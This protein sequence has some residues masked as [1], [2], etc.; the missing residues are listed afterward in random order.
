MPKQALLIVAV[1]AAGGLAALG[2]HAYARQRNA[3]WTAASPEARR[4]FEQGL[5]AELKFYREDAQAHYKKALEL[6][7]QMAMAALRLVDFTAPREKDELARRIADLKTLREQLA[8]RLSE[9]ERLLI[10]YRL[11][12]AAK[13]NARAEKTLSAYLEQHPNDPWA[14]SIRCDQ[15]WQRRDYKEAEKCNRLLIK[16][17]PNWVQAQNQLGYIAMATGRFAEAEQLFRTYLYIAPDQANPHDSMGELFTLLGRYPE[18]ERELEAAVRIRPSFCT[19]WEHL[20]LLHD[21]AGASDKAHAAVDRVEALG[22]CSKDFVERQRC[23]VGT[24]DGVLKNDPAESWQAASSMGCSGKGGEVSVLAYHAALR[25]GHD[26]DAAIIESDMREH[27][28]LYG[29]DDPALLALQDHLEGAR[30]VL[31]G[32]LKTAAARFA[33]ADQHLLYWSDNLGLMK[34]F[35]L[36]MLARCQ[37]A[38]GDTAKADAADAEVEAVNKPFAQRFEK[39]PFFA[40]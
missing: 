38:I 26:A 22:A 1:V 3:R 29:E 16:A 10:D 18:G 21:L 7:P 40:P 25:S 12:R 5:E 19:S 14:L 9:R 15:A 4:E 23:R 11:Q 27:A 36:L 39:A 32:D 8:D 37:R 17:D 35:N 34:L 24:W 20:I 2:W 13:E 33:S 28:H 30:L 31:G 6:D